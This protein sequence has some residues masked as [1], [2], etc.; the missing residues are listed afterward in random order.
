M[1]SKNKQPLASI[2]SRFFQGSFMNQ[3]G[4]ISFEVQ[5]VNFEVL[6]QLQTVVLKP[7]SLNQFIYSPYIFN[8][9]SVDIRFAVKKEFDT[10]KVLRLFWSFGGHF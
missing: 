8:D 2:D 5:M 4:F 7:N 9:T 1:R 6:W 10:N 3:H